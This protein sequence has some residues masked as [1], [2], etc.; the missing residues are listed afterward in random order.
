MSRYAVQRAI[1]DHL[2]TLEDPS[3]TVNPASVSVDG[4]AVTPEETR[5]LRN[6]DV[7]A[8]H[9]MGVHPVLIN[10]YCRANGWKGPSYRVLFAAV[11]QIDVAGEARW[12][13]S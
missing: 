4:Y 5:A 12:R 10:A 13:R 6:G 11:D 7:A 9:R 1:F 3:R 2:R 8:Y